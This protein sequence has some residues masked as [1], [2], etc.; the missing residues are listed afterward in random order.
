MQIFRRIIIGCLFAPM[1]LFGAIPLGK[2]HYW[3][4][5][6]DKGQTD[7][8]L[9]YPSRYLSAKSI[10]R[11]AMRGIPITQEDLPVNTGYIDALTACGVQVVHRSKW[12]N[13]VVIALPQYN[14]EKILHMVTH[15]RFVDNKHH[16]LT[17]QRG[18]DATS[19]LTE[20]DSARCTAMCSIDEEYLAPLQRLNSGGEGVRIA[21]LDEGFEGLMTHRAFDSL[22]L[23]DRLLGIKSFK[24]QTGESA[25]T[26]THGTE[27]L[28]VLASNDA[29]HLVGIAPD[30]DYLLL[31]TED[32]CHELPL[33]EYQWIAAMEYADSVGVDM[34]TSSLGYTFFDEGRYD[35]HYSEL[36]QGYAHISR[37]A[38]AAWRKGICVVVSAGN[39]GESTWQHVIF[40]GEAREVI[41]VGAVDSTGLL[42]PFSS[43]G[44]SYRDYIKPDL[45]T[46]G[47]MVRTVDALTQGGYGYS[48]GTSFS[49]PIIAG[50]LACLYPYWRTMRLDQLKRLLLESCSLRQE[51]NMGYGHGVP[52]C[53]AL[54]QK[55]TH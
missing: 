15:L 22:R 16:S 28:S 1:V 51:P 48:L 53:E 38:Q 25:L 36:G 2:S 44:W 34:V 37:V 9:L 6:T 12:L 14:K 33:E 30:A 45:V 23:Q 43:Q 26:G 20:I 18:Y 49:T 7:S 8:L 35:H 21:I 5:F 50:M 32:G 13:G 54:I 41:T 10:E 27:V 31:A 4:A 47:N 3:V 42:M 46:L 19:A 11:R 40:P 52:D 39:E 55:L 24:L 17:K 29:P